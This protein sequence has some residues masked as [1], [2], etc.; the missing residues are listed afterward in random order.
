MELPVLMLIAMPCLRCKTHVVRCAELEGLAPQ[1]HPLPPHLEALLGLSLTQTKAGA[2][3]CPEALTQY[4][5]AKVLSQPAPTAKAAVAWLSFI[6][7]HGSQVRRR[8]AGGRAATPLAVLSMLRRA[9]CSSRESRHTA[10]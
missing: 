9:P 2:A 8:T 6:A 3:L 4:V 10:G 7:A 1:V 5:V